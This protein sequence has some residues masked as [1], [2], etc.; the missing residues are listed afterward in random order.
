MTTKNMPEGFKPVEDVTPEAENITVIAAPRWATGATV[1]YR[2]VR[3]G[4]KNGEAW[5]MHVVSHPKDP[6]GEKYGIWATAKLDRLFARVRV[7]TTAYIRYDG[8]VPHPTIAG[9]EIHEWT[10]AVSAAA[11][12]P[13]AVPSEAE[14][15]GLPAAF[16]K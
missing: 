12:A 3:E 5:R 4:K 9:S 10:V 1:V 8:K 15:D 6:E 11:P 16:A 2:G 7:G 13:A 14:G